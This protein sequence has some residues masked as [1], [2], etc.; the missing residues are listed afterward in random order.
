MY[1]SYS[2]VSAAVLASTSYVAVA[3][4]ASGE[5]FACAGGIAVYATKRG[6]MA[7]RAS[8]TAIWIIARVRP[9]TGGAPVTYASERAF[10]SVTASSAFADTGSPSATPAARTSTGVSNPRRNGSTARHFDSSVRVRMA[11]SS[12]GGALCAA[13]VRPHRGRGA[14]GVPGAIPPQRPCD[15]TGSVGCESG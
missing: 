15:E 2:W 5:A 14:N 4:A 13:L 11:P 10:Q 3:T 8:C 1:V 12:S 6:A 7:L 9:W